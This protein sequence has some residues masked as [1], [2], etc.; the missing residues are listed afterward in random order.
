[1]NGLTNEQIVLDTNTA[2]DFIDGRIA[3]LPGGK[4]FVSVITEMELFACPSLTPE[5][6]QDIRDFLSFVTIV[7][8]KEQIKQEAIRI[9]KYGEPRLKLPDSIVA[10]T[11]IVLGAALITGDAKILS[12]NWPGLTLAGSR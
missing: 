8:L 6:E 10:A 12:L 11:A 7:P 9:R 3:A 4:R 2:I 1:M 5:D